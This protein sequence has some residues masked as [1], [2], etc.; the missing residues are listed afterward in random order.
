MRVKYLR[1]RQQ[2]EAFLNSSSHNQV[3][4]AASNDKNDLQRKYSMINKLKPMVQDITQGIR[5]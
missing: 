3:K 4:S 2:N 5:L 1:V